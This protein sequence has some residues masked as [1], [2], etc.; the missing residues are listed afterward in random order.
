[1]TAKEARQK[2]LDTMNG[3]EN[4]AVEWDNIMKGIENATKEYNWFR[5]IWRSSRRM[6]LGNWLRLFE[7]GYFV[8]VI[9]NIDGYIEYWIYF[10]KDHKP[11]SKDEIIKD[12]YLQPEHEIKNTY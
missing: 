1:M 5:T 3:F 7:L 12:Y 4:K 8:T 11:K 10:D 9:W 6:N 2:T